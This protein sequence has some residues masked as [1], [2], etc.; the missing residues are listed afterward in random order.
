[1]A[2]SQT[3]ESRRGSS[4]G[5]WPVAVTPQ[6]SN[7]GRAYRLFRRV[8]KAWILRVIVVELY[9]GCCCA[10]HGLHR[11]PC[12]AKCG[13][14]G[15]FHLVFVEWEVRISS[16]FVWAEIVWRRGMTPDGTGISGKS[17]GKSVWVKVLMHRVFCCSRKACGSLESGMLGVQD[18][19]EGVGRRKTGAEVWK[20]RFFKRHYSSICCWPIRF[21]CLLAPSAYS[22]LPQIS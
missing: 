11:K 8:H 21:E 2:V 22:P 4:T 9:F 10:E 12:S 19:T 18:L 3:V 16:G 1:V 13:S 20:I 5:K 7:N 6:I 17:W 14:A 15:V